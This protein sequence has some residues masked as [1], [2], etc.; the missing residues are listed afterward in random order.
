VR[1]SPPLRSPCASFQVIALRMYGRQMFE[2]FRVAGEGTLYSV[3][4]A[5][6][7]ELYAVVQEARQDDTCG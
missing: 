5:D 4:T 3:A 6:L 1:E 2:A 7:D